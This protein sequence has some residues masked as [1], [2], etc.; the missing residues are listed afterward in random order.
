V[1]LAGN[2]DASMLYGTTRPISPT[3]RLW[4]AYLQLQCWWYLQCPLVVL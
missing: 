3:G 4:G 1:K 2:K